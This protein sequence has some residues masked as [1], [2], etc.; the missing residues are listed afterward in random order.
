MLEPPAAAASPTGH[1]IDKA[2]RLSSSIF[3]AAAT[4]GLDA[5]GTT[6]VDQASPSTDVALGNHLR[7]A[8]GGFLHPGGRRQ[9]SDTYSLTA[10]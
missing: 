10:Y 2:S 6:M 7:F 3:A 4:L 9:G 5:F 1:P 8:P